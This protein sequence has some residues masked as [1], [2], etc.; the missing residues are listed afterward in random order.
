MMGFGFWGWP[1]HPHE[2]QGWFGH[3]MGKTSIFFFFFN[4]LGWLNHRKL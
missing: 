1:N 3:P 4:P 2:P